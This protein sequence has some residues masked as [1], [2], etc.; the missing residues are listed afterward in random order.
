MCIA[1]V[2]YH[3]IHTNSFDSKLCSVCLVMSVLKTICT[4]VILCRRLYWKKEKKKGKK[5]EENRTLAFTP[6]AVVK[7]LFVTCTRTPRMKSV[8]NYDSSAHNSFEIT[9]GRKLYFKSFKWSLCPVCVGFLCD[10]WLPPISQKHAYTKLAL[11]WM[12]VCVCVNV[13]PS[14]VHSCLCVP[15]S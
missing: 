14:R 12:S 11:R 15:S 4:V 2:N 7:S 5:R 1:V 3:A 10:L 9:I 6:Y 13:C 8:V